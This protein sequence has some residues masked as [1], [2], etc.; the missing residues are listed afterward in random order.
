MTLIGEGTGGVYL[1]IQTSR[2]PLTSIVM[3][4]GVK[5]RGNW[6]KTKGVNLEANLQKEAEGR[7]HQRIL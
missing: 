7:K 2:G 4:I 1:Q 3:I 6:L 5:G